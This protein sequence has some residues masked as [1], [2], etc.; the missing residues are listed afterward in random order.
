MATKTPWA[1]LLCKFKDDVIDLKSFR[2]AAKR[3][4]FDQFGNSARAIL[5][6]R[7]DMQR[8]VSMKELIRNISEPGQ[9]LQNEVALFTAPDIENVVTYWQDISYGELDLSGSE[10][11]GWLTLDQNRSDYTIRD[12]FLE[13]WGKKAAADAGI[14]LSRF[15]GVVVFLND[16]T[17]LYGKSKFVAADIASNFSQIL[18][19]VGHGYDLEHSRSVAN[20]TD[21]QDPFCIM[22]GLTF[23]GA[24]PTFQGRFGQSG[25]GLCSPYVFQAGWLAE[26]RITRVPTNG[27]SPV[28]TDLVLSPLSERSPAHPQV[29]MFDLTVPQ[30]YKYFVEYRSGGWD[31]GLNQTAVVIH[32]LRPDKVAYYAGSIATSTGFSGGGFEGGT[33]TLPGGPYADPQFNLSV[34][35]L[36]LLEDRA[37][38]IRIAPK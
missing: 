30:P 21:Y 35:V 15:Y 32:Q 7:F 4:P 23:G 5:A 8:P 10:V 13:I 22:S 9:V 38:N 29:A 37:V 20:P 24:N 33:V 3:F 26:S 34:Q 17:D 12:S 16:A 28:A 27:S 11:F 1:I 2:N 36:S 31:R 18:Q 19:E 6:R 25:P 14:D